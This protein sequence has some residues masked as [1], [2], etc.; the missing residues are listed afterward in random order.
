M[1]VVSTVAGVVV[2]RESVAWYQPVVAAV[3]LLGAAITQTL[4]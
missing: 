3:V 1:P 2:L 4:Q